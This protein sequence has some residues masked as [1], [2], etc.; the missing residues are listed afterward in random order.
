MALETPTTDE[1]SINIVSQLEASLSQTIPLLPKA[2]A[3]VLAKVLAAV[4]VLVYRFAGFSFL[5]IFIRFASF[6]ETEVNG[7]KLTP[8]IEIGR[9][10]DVGDPID[11]E[12]AEMVINVTVTN[13]IGNLPGGS[14]LVRADTGVIYQTIAAIP[15]SSAVVQPT[16]RAVSDP[17]G[18]A[19]V[20]AIGN[21]NDGD[22]I[23]F[24]NP[25]PNV[26]TDAT[27]DSTTILGV[28][29][30]SEDTYRARVLG[31][32]QARP[33][34]GARADYRIW[35]GEVAGVANIYPYAGAP[36][37]VDV[38]VE[39]T[40]TESNPDG[41][42]NGDG[43]LAL[44]AAAIELDDDGLASRRPVT[45]GVTTK[46]IFRTGFQLEI[47]G[48]S[49]P[50]LAGTQALLTTGVD[51]YLRDREPFIVGLSVLPRRDRITQGA[52]AG[53]VNDIV[54]AEGGTVTTVVLKLLGLQ[55]NA[56]SLDNGEKAKLETNG[57]T[58]I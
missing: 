2:F 15:L 8:L 3:R 49:S 56:H 29:G 17:L 35:G 21:L 14:Q 58:Y 10:I 30:E 54:S 22:I 33:Q 26:A 53:V 55:I 39:S 41:I 13:Q 50:D 38:F 4:V 34:G 23:S 43:L 25:L 24:A 19:G 40:A 7:S 28:D 6:Q 9:E 46:P 37:E 44:V 48:L 45:A 5:Q 42:P 51:E 47:G 27:V 11:G 12:Q 52:L 18:N 31:V 16:V 20:G 1:L 36:G 57:I 32:S